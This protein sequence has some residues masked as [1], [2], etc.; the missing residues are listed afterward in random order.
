MNNLKLLTLASLLAFCPA[1]SVADSDVINLPPAAPNE[2]STAKTCAEAL[3]DAE[4]LRNIKRTDGDTNPELG[5]VPE[6]AAERAT[7]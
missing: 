7:R 2:E 3:R 6:C 1:V 4:F 5:E